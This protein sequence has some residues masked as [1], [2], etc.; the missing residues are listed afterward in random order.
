MQG[1]MMDFPL[2]IPH[3]LERAR[4]YFAGNL[5]VSRIADG[6]HRYTWG[7]FGDRVERLAGALHRLG[8]RRGDRVGTF[9][10]NGWRHLEAYF[11]APCMGAVIHTLNIRLFADQLVHVINHAGDEV[12][13]VDASLYPA[14]A[15]VRDRLPAV[16][17]VI[18]MDDVGAGAPPGTLDYEALLADA[19]ATFD[20]PELDEREAAG[21]CYTS[22]TTGHPKGCVYSHRSQVLHTLGMSVGKCVD[23]SETDVSL[24]IVPMFHANAWGMPYSAAMLGLKLVLPGRFM[25]A[26][27]LA[28]LIPAEGVTY[29]A[30]V[31]TIVA[32]IYQALRQAP[33]DLR[34]LR[35]ITVGGAALPRVLLE[36]FE[37]DFGIDVVQGWGMTEMS[38]VGTLARLKKRMEDWPAEERTRARLKAGL[39]LPFVDVR[40]VDDAGRTLP[41]DGQATGELEVR[42]PWVISSYYDDA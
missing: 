42:G 22:G 35:L 24:L 12:V 4:R 26:G 5:I 15:A 30:G 41:W 37:R 28:D 1:L 14:F 3:L 19:P 11:A 33:R 13:L 7:E 18:L 38:P 27:E 36:G 16:K 2:T 9:A 6:T 39:P 29:I 20:W 25:Q 32:G 31:P 21:M 23:L 10:W 8:V 34:T 17:H 40:I